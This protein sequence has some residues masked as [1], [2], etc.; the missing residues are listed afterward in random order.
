MEGALV[1]TDIWSTTSSYGWNTCMGDPATKNAAGVMQTSYNLA[2]IKKPA[3]TIIVGDTGTVA[4][5]GNLINGYTMGARNPALQ[6]ATLASA[7]IPMFRHNVERTVTKTFGTTFKLPV[8]GRANFCFLD[9]HSKS[10]SVNQAFEVGPTVGGVPTEDGIALD[11][12]PAPE[13]ILVP[14][15]RYVLW[16]IY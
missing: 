14:N 8:A 5:N 16:N 2:Q 15:S 7:S 9:G 12:T 10:L 11:T 13:A 1:T 6:P 4:D 3:S